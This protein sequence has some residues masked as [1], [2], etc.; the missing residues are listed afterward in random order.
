MGN[1]RRTKN[2]GGLVTFM[3]ILNG[4]FNLN[5]RFCIGRATLLAWAQKYIACV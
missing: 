3:P 1:G 5:N 4:N 2:G